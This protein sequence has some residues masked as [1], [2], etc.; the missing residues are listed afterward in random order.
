VAG[1]VALTARIAG[2]V[3]HYTGTDPAGRAIASAPLNELL[4]AVP[5]HLAALASVTIACLLLWLI[6]PPLRGLVATL[7]AL[8]LA[9]LV[10]LGQV[11]FALARHIGTGLSFS[12]L[13]TYVGQNLI[14]TE[15]TQPLLADA[16][17]VARACA[18]VL[19]AWAAIAWGR[20]RVRG[21]VFGPRQV[22]G[23]VA[24]LA[25]PIAIRLAVGPGKAYAR[26]PETWMLHALAAGQRIPPPSDYDR[27]VQHLRRIIDAPTGTRWLDP[28][29]PL[30]HQS[31]PRL[32]SSL[33]D[34][35]DIFLFM[36]ESLRGRD[37]QFA[38]LRDAET[39]PTPHLD[40]LAARGV[41]F[42]RFLAN[43]FPSAP[44]FFAIHTGLW[45]HIDKI[46]TEHFEGTEVDALPPRL[47]RAGYDTTF[48]FGANPSFDNILAW[49]R[50]WYAHLEYQ[51]PGNQ[52]VYTRRMSDQQIMQRL[53]EAVARHD[54]HPAS[55]HPLFAFIGTA[56]THQPYT[57]ENSLFSPLSAAGDASRVDTGG[58]TDVQQRYDIVIRNLDEELGHAIE[59]LERRPR[60]AHTVVIIIGDHANYTN[61]VVPDELRGMPTD[62][63]VWTGAIVLGPAALVG[64]PRRETWPCSQVD[65]MPTLLALAGDAGPTAA[66]GRDLFDAD[67]GARRAVAVRPPGFRL[68]RGSSTLMVSGT[69]ARQAWTYQSFGPMMRLR[70]PGALSPFSDADPQTLSQAV[71]LTAWLLEQNRIW[72]ESLLNRSAV[73]P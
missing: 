3:M 54:A 58:V 20:R 60:W 10:L 28:S 9:A 21:L 44:G 11:N 65:L 26:P 25:I 17:Y 43:G 13:A 5:E 67:D 6:V 73:M 7:S 36:V 2:L 24:V 64:S 18:L 63:S 56:G 53:L 61:D 48:V 35:P 38:G 40:R 4:I 50:R 70:A 23:A 27:S 68:D 31:P 51:L 16:P 29:L 41:V 45:P 69:T 22:L 66:M 30:V 55:G 37:T 1:L 59:A 49:A 14:S 12:I 39:S 46:P 52:I 57:L 15:V 72:R 42:P 19:L 62:D 47:A 32:R 33:E 8:L 71:R 34:L